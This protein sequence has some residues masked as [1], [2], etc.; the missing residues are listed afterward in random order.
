MTAIIGKPALKSFGAQVEEER[1]Q[2]L[3]RLQVCRQKDAELSDKLMKMQDLEE[4]GMAGRLDLQEPIS[5]S[6][7]SNYHIV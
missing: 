1:Q 3:I 6:C 7:R 4:E 2:I 5:L